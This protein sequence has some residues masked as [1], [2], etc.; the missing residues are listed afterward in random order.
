MTYP[1]VDTDEKTTRKLTQLKA[2]GVT[3]VIRYINPLNTKADKCVDNQEAKAIAEAGMRLG[4]VCEGWG[5]AGPG[6]LSAS[7]NQTQGE[8]D[9]MICRDFADKVAGAPAGACIYYA[10]DTDAS[11]SE[12]TSYVLPYFRRVYSI[13]QDKNRQGPIYQVGVY[14]S[15]LVCQVL[16]DAALVHKTWLAQSTGWRGYRA[17][18]D[19]NKWALLQ[20]MPQQIAGLDCDPDEP[21][22][23]QDAGLF[24]PFGGAI[25]PGPA[26]S[27]LFYI[28]DKLNTLLKITPPLVVDGVWGPKT[29]AAVRLALDQLE[30]ELSA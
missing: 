8:R 3:S 7:I 26:L 11:P 23:L 21:N 30:K 19:G 20:H 15:G 24:V 13:M 14:S 22:P 9:A 17:Y 29:Q 1:I 2:A 6:G 28:Q 12:I 5:G 16:Q 4:L 10:V 25:T 27:G 18:H